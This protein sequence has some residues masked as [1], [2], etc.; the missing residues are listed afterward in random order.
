[1]TVNM[2]GCDYL[3]HLGAEGNNATVDLVCPAGKDATITAGG[4]ACVA[5]IAPFTGK[6]N[7]ALSNSTPSGKVNAVADVAGIGASLTD[8]SSFFCPFA[9]ST[10]TSTATYTGNLTLSGSS[11]ID[12]G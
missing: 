8:V 3:F 7:V 9:G 5:H 12:I 6:S 4:G 2:N 1:A 10:T 11:E